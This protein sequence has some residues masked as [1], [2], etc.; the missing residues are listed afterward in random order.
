MTE[1]EVK[2]LETYLK[3]LSTVSEFSEEELPVIGVVPAS[4]K[5]TFIFAPVRIFK[6]YFISFPYEER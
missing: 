2:E 3:V 4:S 6:E 1:E 5:K